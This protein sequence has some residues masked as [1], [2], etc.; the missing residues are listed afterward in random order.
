MLAI[1]SRGSARAASALNLRSSLQPVGLPFPESPATVCACVTPLSCVNN[2]SSV[3]SEVPGDSVCLISFGKVC[4]LN[5]V[6]LGANPGLCICWTNATL[7][8]P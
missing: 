4:V 1:G 8:F 5:F 3:L 7:S 6:V 2:P